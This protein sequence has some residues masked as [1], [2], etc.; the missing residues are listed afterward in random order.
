MPLA[1]DAY[2]LV[3]MDVQMPE[4]DGLEATARI[5]AAEPG[6]ESAHPD[7][8]DDRARDER[9][10]RALPRGRHGRLRGQADQAGATA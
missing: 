8:G 3:L 5:R 1:R 6:D 2:D 10:P 9:R 7:R 4:M